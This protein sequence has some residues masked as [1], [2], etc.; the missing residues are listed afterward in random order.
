MVPLPVVAA[1]SEVDV[2]DYSAMISSSRGSGREIA[3]EEDKDLCVCAPE[4]NQACVKEERLYVREEN[5][6]ALALGL[7]AMKDAEINDSSESTLLIE[8]TGDHAHGNTGDVADEVEDV[9]AKGFTISALTALSGD[10]PVEPGYIGTTSAQEKNTSTKNYKKGRRKKAKMHVHVVGTCSSD[11]VR[12]CTAEEAEDSS[13]SQQRMDYKKKK[14]PKKKNKNDRAA[15]E[16]KEDDHRRPAPQKYSRTCCGAKNDDVDTQKVKDCCCQFLTIFLIICWVVGVVCQ[17]VGLVLQ[18]KNDEE[19]STTSARTPSGGTT[20]LA[21]GGSSGTTNAAAHA[22]LTV[23]LTQIDADRYYADS[24]HGAENRHS[25]TLVSQIAKNLRHG[26]GIGGER[27]RVDA[28]I[29]LVGDGFLDNSGYLGRSDYYRSSAA[30]ASASSIQVRGPSSS[31]KQ[32]T[33]TALGETYGLFMEYQLP[34]IA[35]WINFFL[36]D[37]EVPTRSAPGRGD[38]AK[39]GT[40]QV[41]MAAEAGSSLQD[42]IYFMEGGTSVHQSRS[43]SAAGFLSAAARAG[44][45]S[46]DAASSSTRKL[47]S[48]V[49]NDVAVRQN[50]QR[51]DAIVLHLGW[52]ELVYPDILK[53]FISRHFPELDE[54]QSRAGAADQQDALKRK[55]LQT[56]LTWPEKLE[57]LYRELMQRHL[58]KY[59]KFLTGQACS[60]TSEEP[61]E[62]LGERKT[63]GQGRGAPSVAQIMGQQLAEVEQIQNHSRELVPAAGGKN[64]R[65]TIHL[66][67]LA[68][69]PPEGPFFKSVLRR[70]FSKDANKNKSVDIDLATILSEDHWARMVT[71]FRAK[72]GTERSDFLRG[73]NLVAAPRGHASGLAAA[74]RSASADHDTEDSMLDEG[75][76]V[77]KIREISRRKVLGKRRNNH[78]APPGVGSSSSM[79]LHALD[80]VHLN[81]AGSRVLGEALAK[82]VKV[83]YET[84]TY[85]GRVFDGAELA[86]QCFCLVPILLL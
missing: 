30:S 6:E 81:E 46:Q 60:C 54:E 42:R 65:I 4:M 3:S 48:K 63:N 41:V 11:G 38:T 86:V 33:T 13:T 15:T 21:P 85:S 72:A 45:T 18:I 14:Q 26:K 1:S 49:K 68:L 8:D 79:Q 56:S 64:A 78:A 62:E 7:D 29:F 9:V 10:P 55:I 83:N 66:L 52:S 67:A 75:C 31:M 32:S 36:L 73:L 37:D 20:V 19:S 47:T 77:V 58:R 25:G 76:V 28:L 16:D 69:G 2:G 27:F 22:R 23:P 74:G 39:V 12:D 80:H 40:K 82:R 34:D 59:L 53:T 5:Q 61:Q 35:Y 84:S 24:T 70:A 51:G 17:I 44:D 50:I 43:S 71:L 57:E